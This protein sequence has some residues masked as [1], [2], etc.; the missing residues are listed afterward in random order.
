LALR[1]LWDAA[2]ESLMRLAEEAHRERQAL[3]IGELGA[4]VGERVE[5]IAHLLDVG[6]G[7]GALL[8]AILGLEGEQV[9]EGRLR[10]LDLRREARPLC[11]RTRR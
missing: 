11:G 10:S 5:V 4:R 6:V 7:R 3:G 2:R 1:E 8:C 9:D